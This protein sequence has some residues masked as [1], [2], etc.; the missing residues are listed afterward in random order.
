MPALAAWIAQFG[1]AS[2][3]SIVLT[4]IVLRLT[5]RSA[6]MGTLAQAGP[7]PQLGLGGRMAAA[8]IAAT[9]VT[10][11]AASALG[12]RLGLPTF[13]AGAATGVVIFIAG[14]ES[15]VDA[16]KGVSWSV[17]P[18]VAG[19]FVLAQAIE[20]TGVLAPIVQ[21]LSAAAASS[22]HATGFAAGSAL[23][24]IC[25]AM[26]NLPLGLIAGS[27]V[28]GAPLAPSLAAAMLIG[29]D[30]GPN[31]SITGSLATLLWL[32]ALRREG[33][34]VSALGFLAVGSVV[35]PPALIGSLASVS[36]LAPG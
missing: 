20:S 6:L 17:L 13:I 10:L 7:L 24:I 28:H 26:N 1:A 35:M 29:V 18:L 30:L 25:N 19:L 15:P 33:E 22:P 8:G 3:V 5:Q 12:W 34:Q 21:R 4:F 23:A 11:L 31:L 36:W 27:L 14:R 9:A 16:L 32:V 2:L